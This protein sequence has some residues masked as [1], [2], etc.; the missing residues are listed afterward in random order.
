MMYSRV[1][2]F[3]L[4]HGFLLYAQG[5]SG[6][7]QV[8]VSTSVTS[9]KVRYQYQVKNVAGAPIVRFSVGVDELGSGDPELLSQ[10]IGWDFVAEAGTLAAPSNWRAKVETFD[11]SAYFNITWTRLAGTI[12]IQPGDSLDGFVVDLRMADDHYRT[13]H[14][15]VLRDDGT[16]TSG[17]LQATDPLVAGD[18]NGDGK[19]DCSDIAIVKA[20]FGRKA[21]DSLFDARADTNNDGSVDVR[22]LAT[23]AQHLPIGTHCQ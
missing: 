20:G 4:L 8:Q 23:V 12:H 19:V 15:T 14:W 6:Q 18:V 3:A 5:P 11:E 16:M 2:I 17:V 7:A 21:G 22:D 10:P 9:G 1:A 13:A